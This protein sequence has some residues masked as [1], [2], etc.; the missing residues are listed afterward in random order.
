MPKK[1]YICGC[2]R[3][4]EKYLKKVFNNIKQIGEQFDEYKI[5]IAYDESTDN[6]YKLLLT[7]KKDFK[8]MEIIKNTNPLSQTCRTENICNARNSIMD[9]I[10]KDNNQEYEYFIMMDMDDVN[11]GK[12]NID[13]L[14]KYISEQSINK[15]LWDSLS[16]NRHFYYDLWA[17]SIDKLVFSCWHW[18]NDK[19]Q[20]ENKDVTRFTHQYITNKIYNT[21]DEQLIECYSA[22][23]GFA[24]YKKEKFINCHYEH[25]IRANLYQ[26][27]KSMLEENMEELNKKYYLNFLEDCEHRY[28]HMQSVF[29]NKSKIRISPLILFEEV[30]TM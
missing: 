30:N 10:K 21:N 24:I 27:P 4:C 26:I 5:I 2:T 18:S 25:D 8:N 20:F 17:L 15:N 6:T 14:K 29:T 23:N 28:F 12:M 11:S 22:F 3:N 19:R 16:F 1:C 7:L 13:I 9:Y